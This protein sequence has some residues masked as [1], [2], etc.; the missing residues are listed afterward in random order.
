MTMIFG[1]NCSMTTVAVKITRVRNSDHC[2]WKKQ[3]E[4]YA[5][6]NIWTNDSTLTKA[7]EA[8]S[9]DWT[10]A[11][12]PFSDNEGGLAHL[13]RQLKEGSNESLILIKGDSKQ[14]RT[15]RLNPNENI[16]IPTTVIYHK[17]DGGFHYSYCKKIA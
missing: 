16:E 10:K 7:I 5:D 14:E 17:G 4:S 8:L 3:Y 15:Y 2:S 11:A 13:L 9:S 12:Y 6:S 1:V